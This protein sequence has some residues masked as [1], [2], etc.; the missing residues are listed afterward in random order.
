MDLFKRYIKNMNI[1]SCI[2]CTS[3]SFTVQFPKELC[4]NMKHF[5]NIVETIT[6]N[7]INHASCLKMSFENTK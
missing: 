7:M 5:M 3:V 6:K 2:P 1:F 4:M